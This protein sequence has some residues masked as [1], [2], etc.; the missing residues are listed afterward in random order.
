[1]GYKISGLRCYR[2][3]R[4]WPPNDVHLLSKQQS[5][6]PILEPIQTSRIERICRPELFN[7]T[8]WTVRPLSSFSWRES[9]KLIGERWTF[10]W[11][12]GRTS[13]VLIR[14]FSTS[15]N[16]QSCKPKV[17]V[18]EKWKACCLARKTYV[19]R[20]YDGG[21]D[22][23]GYYCQHWVPYARGK[24]GCTTK[25]WTRVLCMF[26]KRPCRT[27]LRN[28]CHCFEEPH[29]ELKKLALM[30]NQLTF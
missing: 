15:S 18:A 19:R 2:L 26:A 24:Y 11:G 29:E 22:D 9:V 25:A 30:K 27:I 6:V 8:S 10:S 17:V 3:Q 14:C 20:I 21:F 5:Q 28:E 16:L 12:S 13:F 7:L 23:A 4:D 1:M